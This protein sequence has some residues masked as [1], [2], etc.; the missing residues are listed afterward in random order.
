MVSPD[1][2]TDIM[3]EPFDFIK[4]LASAI[5]NSYNF[6]INSSNPQ[7]GHFFLSSA[8]LLHTSQHAHSLSMSNIS[9]ANLDTALPLHSLN[10]QDLQTMLNQLV[11][12]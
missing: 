1:S 11:S 12:I 2:R 4:S 10:P 5:T 8:P 6:N 7:I 9:I 3:P